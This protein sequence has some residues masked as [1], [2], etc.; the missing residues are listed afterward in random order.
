MAGKYDS[1]GLACLVCG[2]GKAE[3]VTLANG[4]KACLCPECYADSFRK[5]EAERR[6][7]K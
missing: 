2:R 3:R 5:A 6:V 4:V 7:A 1:A